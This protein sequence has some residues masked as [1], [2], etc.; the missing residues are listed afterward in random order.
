MGK[1]ITDPRLFDHDPLTGTTE[2]FHYNPDDGSFQ[3][4]RRQDVENI[5]ELNKALY[6]NAPLRWG[7]GHLA[8]II[9][10]VIVME[11][12]KQGIMRGAGVILDHDRFKKWLNDRDNL[13][14][15]VR[16]GKI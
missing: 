15:R 16:P 2:Y 10:D 5:I 12:T 9:P 3:I 14:W 8:A 1:S 6:N 11:L 4:E 7:D 13:A